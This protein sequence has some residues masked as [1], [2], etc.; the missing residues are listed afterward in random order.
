MQRWFRLSALVLACILSA[1]ISFAQK[2]LVQVSGR[3]GPNE[4]RIFLQDAIYQ[5]NGTYMIA[6]T[7][8]IEPGTKVLFLENER[9]IDTEV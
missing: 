9:I 3:L 7:L 6:G 2:P 1:S 8:I 5:I 4:V